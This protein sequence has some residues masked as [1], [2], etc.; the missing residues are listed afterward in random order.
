MQGKG[1]L[2][3]NFTIKCKTGWNSPSANLKPKYY[4]DQKL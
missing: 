2:P 1:K 3:G 4:A